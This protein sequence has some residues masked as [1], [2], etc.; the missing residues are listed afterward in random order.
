MGPA[1]EERGPGLAQVT[2]PTLH[3]RLHTHL[4][5]L[6][7]RFQPLKPFSPPHCQPHHAV[8]SLPTGG[9]WQVL[10]RGTSR[11]PCPH[12][13]CS[14]HVPRGTVP[15]RG[16]KAITQIPWF[17]CSPR[18]PHPSKPLGSGTVAPAPTPD[19]GPDPEPPGSS[20]ALPTRDQALR[21]P[22][23][24]TAAVLAATERLLVFH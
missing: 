16:P 20:R 13:H 22:A 24:G 9:T 7:G 10:E 5:Q 23:P 15:P 21:D 4:V 11:S 18:P 8:P 3:A 12:P 1:A 17:P 2:A 14:P 19:P 6:Q